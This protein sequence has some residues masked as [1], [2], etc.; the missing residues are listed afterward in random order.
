MAVQRVSHIPGAE[1]WSY[2][3]LTGFRVDA[4]RPSLCSHSLGTNAFQTSVIN[5]QTEGDTGKNANVQDAG[6]S[7]GCLVEVKPLVSEQQTSLLI[8]NLRDQAEQGKSHFSPTCHRSESGESICIISQPLR[9]KTRATNI[10]RLMTFLYYLRSSRNF[11][12]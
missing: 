3:G 9:K 5:Q 8:Y 12:K 10:S 7:E 4:E 11:K 2:T 6:A 1:I